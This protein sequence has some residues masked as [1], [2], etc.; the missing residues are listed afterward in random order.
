MGLLDRL[1]GTKKLAIPDALTPIGRP[2]TVIYGGY[3]Y[4]PEKD[5]RLSDK[6]KYITYSDI[7][8]NMSIVAAGVRY[9]LNLVT[10]SRWKLKTPDDSADCQMY[11]ELVED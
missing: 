1:L 6:N 7:M 11:A 4:S 9:F 10:K 8:V 3:L 2:G 5:A